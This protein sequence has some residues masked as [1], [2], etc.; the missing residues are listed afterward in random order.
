MDS[1]Y[2]LQHSNGK[3]KWHKYLSI[4]NF[5]FYNMAPYNGLTVAIEVMA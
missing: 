2:F 1:G 4:E 5:S 3:T